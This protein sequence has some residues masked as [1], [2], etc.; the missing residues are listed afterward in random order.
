[1]VEA[2]PEYKLVAENQLDNGFQ[3]SPAA[4]GPALYLRSTTHLYCIEE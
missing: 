2:S 3:A 4:I 1:M